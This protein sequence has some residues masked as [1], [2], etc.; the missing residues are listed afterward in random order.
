MK[1]FTRSIIIILPSDDLAVSYPLI[2]ETAC[3]L[4]YC[5]AKEHIPIAMLNFG[6]AH[7]IL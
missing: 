6:L 7:S 2:C 3:S 5:H 4:S 1:N